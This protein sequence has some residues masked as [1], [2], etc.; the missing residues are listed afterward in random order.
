MGTHVERSN[1]HL[2]FS[3]HSIKTE[4]ITASRAACMKEQTQNV[5]KKSSCKNVD[6]EDK[7]VD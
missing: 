1:W 5:T 7:C 2:A 6:V 4:K 3:F